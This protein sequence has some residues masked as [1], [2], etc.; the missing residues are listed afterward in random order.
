MSDPLRI[1]YDPVSAVDREM[2]LVKAQN[3]DLLRQLHN[4]QAEV[5][6]LKDELRQIHGPECLDGD[7][8]DYD[9]EH[10][11]HHSAVV[12]AHEAGQKVV[13]EEYERLK[14]EIRQYGVK[15]A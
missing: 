13:R 7:C 10:P 9:G 3:A 12:K 5:E 4:A 1:E 2:K 14:A 8:P 15:L 11:Y 6:R